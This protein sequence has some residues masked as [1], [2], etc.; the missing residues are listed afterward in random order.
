MRISTA[1]TALK[2]K[3]GK[4]V[5]TSEKGC[6]AASFDSSKISFLPEA[7]ITPRRAAD[8]GRGADEAPDPT[9]VLYREHLDGAWLRWSV[10]EHDA[11]DVPGVHGPRCLI[12]TS[13]DC[14]RRVWDF[15]V[16]WRALDA[17][18]LTAL[19]WRRE[20]TRRNNGVRAG[21]CRV[22]T[23]CPPAPPRSRAEWRYRRA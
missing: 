15:P 9:P 13:E 10:V 19:S 1:T 23:R 4:L 21:A 7:V 8:I 14:I 12:F 5:D 16:D 2:R 20:A 3:L 18:G 6:W 22:T 11:R 17:V